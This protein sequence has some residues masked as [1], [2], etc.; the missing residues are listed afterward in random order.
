MPT[1][2]RLHSRLDAVEQRLAGVAS[3]DPPPGLTEPDPGG[4]ERWE[5]RQ[6]WGHVAEFV[7]YWM[8]EAER[9]IGAASPEPVP[10][11]RIKTDAARLEAI[12]RG[13]SQAATDLIS[14]VSASIEQVRVFT[15]ELEPREWAALGAHPT[16][17]VM[18]VEDILERFI[19]RHL[20]EH[21]DQ[22]EI[23]ARA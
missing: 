13:R 19:A 11:G 16:L 10:F 17:G 20:E 6:V 21:V 14:R 9:V 2:E 22:L 5:A 18:S 12:E 4:D 3:A 23:L 8:G 7:P 1:A 15:A